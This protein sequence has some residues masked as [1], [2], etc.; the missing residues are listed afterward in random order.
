MNGTK[1]QIAYSPKHEYEY[2][3]LQESHVPIKGHED[4]EKFLEALEGLHSDAAVKMEELLQ[5]VYEL[6]IEQGK[7]LERSEHPIIQ[8]HSSPLSFRMRR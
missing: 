3:S 8:H 6:G 7:R 2:K 5:A 1:V 4:A